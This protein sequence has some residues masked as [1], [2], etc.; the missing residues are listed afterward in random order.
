MLASPNQADSRIELPSHDRHN[1]PEPDPS[2]CNKQGLSCQTHSWKTARALRTSK[3]CISFTRDYALDCQ[4]TVEG[5]LC[6]G[7]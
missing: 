1:C 5:N 4:G 7:F 2:L 3:F 6:E